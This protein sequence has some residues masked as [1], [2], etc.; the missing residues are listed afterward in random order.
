MV[1]GESGAESGEIRGMTAVTT[2][3]HDDSTAVLPRS[4]HTRYVARDPC[5]SPGDF[6]LVPQCDA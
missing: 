2:T 5:T 1:T 6:G 3:H 4:G